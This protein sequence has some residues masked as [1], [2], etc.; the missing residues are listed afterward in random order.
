MFILR[1]SHS[2][3]FLHPQVR[4]FGSSI[5]CYSL[6]LSIIRLPT[7]CIRTVRVGYPGWW[8]IQILSLMKATL[9]AFFVCI[10][11]TTTANRGF[12]ASINEPSVY[13]SSSLMIYCSQSETHL[14]PMISLRLFAVL[15]GLCDPCKR[16]TL[17]MHGEHPLI[18]IRD[19][20]RMW[21]T[22]WLYTSTVP[23]QSLLSFSSY[24]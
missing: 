9:G 24:F 14:L 11:Q 22:M 12:R 17:L 3:P 7:S 6:K 15:R 2:A 1:Q 13:C 19:D 4:R 20:D 10:C 21:T 18:C 8:V 16:Q 23:E 5:S